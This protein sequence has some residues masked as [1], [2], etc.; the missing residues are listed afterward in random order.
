M[1]KIEQKVL[2]A[3]QPYICKSNARIVLSIN[4]KNMEY[5]WNKIMKE[6]ENDYGEVPSYGIPTKYFLD[7]VHIT[8]DDLVLAMETEEKL[9]SIIDAKTIEEAI[10]QIKRLYI[11]NEVCLSE[12]LSDVKLRGFSIED[13]YEIYK[14]LMEDIESDTF[15]EIKEED[16][17]ETYGALIDVVE[18]WL[19]NK[20]IDIPNDER[21][22]EGESKDV[23]IWGEDYD[24]LRTGFKKI[25]E[26]SK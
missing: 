24:N 25:L 12:L 7:K 26:E 23:R 9:G 20:D 15:I 14:K 8:R 19:T 13:A 21:D 2:I 18:D 22:D 16:K 5:I 4:H 6:Y 10:Q 11:E 3:S 17:E 1:N